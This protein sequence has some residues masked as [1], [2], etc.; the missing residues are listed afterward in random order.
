MLFYQIIESV[1][2]VLIYIAISPLLSIIFTDNRLIKL[3]SLA[4]LIV[5]SQGMISFLVGFYNGLR[6]FKIQSILVYLIA[7]VII[8]LFF[9]LF[10]L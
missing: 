6:K 8:H 10:Y 7:I 1:L 5:F 4:S 3:V 2:I 9:R